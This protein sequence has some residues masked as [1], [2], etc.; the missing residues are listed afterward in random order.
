MALNLTAW[1][2][3]RSVPAIFVAAGSRLTSQE[4]CPHI[5]KQALTGLSKNF[6]WL[7]LLS[8]WHQRP[9]KTV[10]MFERTQHNLTRPR[11]RGVILE[12]ADVPVVRRVKPIGITYAGLDRR[13]RPRI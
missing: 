5:F 3:N 8:G 6:I 1:L 7:Y 9:Q 10:K 12:P 4:G 2:K 11:S 13:I